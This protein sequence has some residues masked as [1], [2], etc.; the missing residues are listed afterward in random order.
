MSRT[1]FRCT[2]KKVFALTFFD[3][4][5]VSTLIFP[6][7][8]SSVGVR[9]GN[10]AKYNISFDYTWLSEEPEP[11][12]LQEAKERDWQ[13]VTVTDINGYEVTFEIVTHVKNG[14]TFTNKYIA[15]ILT[16]E[17]L[18][19]TFPVLVTAGLSE[20]DPIVATT[21]TDTEVPS[22]NKTVIM[23]YARANRKVNFVPIFSGYVTWNET[24]GRFQIVGNGSI[25]YFYYDKDTG[26]LCQFE[27][28]TKEGNKSYGLST[29]FNLIMAK[30]NL[31]VPETISGWWWPVLAVIIVVPAVFYYF[32]RT[33]KKRYR[34]FSRPVVRRH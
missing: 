2:F 21:D 29:Y 25:R 12:F 33:R 19:L 11:S 17:T 23:N 10:W 24:E 34:R 16:G 6:A 14:T 30:T 27:S 18:N 15:D 1:R 3:I 5:I 13:N 26:F 32:L 4:L 28:Y 31:W 22:V 7:T 9:S 8:T 20:G